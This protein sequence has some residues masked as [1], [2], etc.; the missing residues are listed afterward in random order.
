MEN[1][2]DLENAGKDRLK[3]VMSQIEKSLKETQEQIKTMATT[4]DK[5]LR[6]NPWPIVAG[7]AATSVL[8]GFVMGASRRNE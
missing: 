6:A 4:A 2:Q 3:N 1:I 8:L 5:Q 7:I